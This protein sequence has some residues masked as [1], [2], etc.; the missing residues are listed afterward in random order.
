MKIPMKLRR[1]VI[2]YKK[3]QRLAVAEPDKPF[4]LIEFSSEGKRTVKRFATDR[5]RWEYHCYV[6]PGRNC[7]R[8]FAKQREL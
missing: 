1:A 7:Y 5:E 2:A 3:R 4:G 8:F 6:P